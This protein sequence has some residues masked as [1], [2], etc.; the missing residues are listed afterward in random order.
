MR[1]LGTALPEDVT[2]DHVVVA[3]F[4]RI[5]AATAPVE[6]LGDRPDQGHLITPVV[7]ADEATASV[8]QAI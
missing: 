3:R 2:D 1:V 5:P 8:R 7:D 4:D 6:L